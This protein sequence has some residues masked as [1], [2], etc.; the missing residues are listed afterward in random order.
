MARIVFFLAAVFSSLFAQAVDVSP[1]SATFRAGNVAPLVTLMDQEV[2]IA[3]PG[4][5]KKCNADE[6]V[7]LLNS[8]LRSNKP[9]DFTTLHNA[10]KKDN[11][12]LVAKLLTSQGEFRVNITYRIGNEK[13]IIQSVRIE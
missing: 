2:D 11:G 7:A 1:I 6:A 12:F 4:A 10:D 9:S 5:T 13:I 3:I 8:F